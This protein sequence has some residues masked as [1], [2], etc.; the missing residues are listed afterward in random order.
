MHTLD[1][2]FWLASRSNDVSQDCGSLL[3]KPRSDVLKVLELL[4]ELG[5]LELFELLEP[6]MSELTD[7]PELGGLIAMFC[8][9]F[10][11]LVFRY[12]TEWSRAHLGFSVCRDPRGN[13]EVRSHWFWRFMTAVMDV[14]NNVGELMKVEMDSMTL[15]ARMA[16]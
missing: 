9:G 12:Y 6:T 7:V 13:M 3:P 16:R 15:E 1:G 4:G 11:R 2:R 14:M 10:A 5:L 8:L